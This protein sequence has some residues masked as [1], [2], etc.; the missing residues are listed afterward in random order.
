MTLTGTLISLWININDLRNL[1]TTFIAE[2]GLLFVV[3]TSFKCFCLPHKANIEIQTSNL[4]YFLILG[5]ITLSYVA[6]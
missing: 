3:R 2:S 6:N 1:E 4:C 5:G